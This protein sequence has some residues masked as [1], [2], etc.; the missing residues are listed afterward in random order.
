MVEAY[1]ALGSN[2]GDREANIKAALQLLK[3][4][5]KIIRT[6]SLYETK[7]M[8]IEK[9]D[10]FLNSAAKIETELPPKKLLAI[11]KHIE[12]KLGRK[13]VERNGPR[14]IDLDIL[15]YDNQIVDEGDLQIPHPK[16]EERAFVLIPL[17][18]IAGDFVHPNKGKIVS[19]LLRNLNYDKSAIKLQNPKVMTQ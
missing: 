18:E 19:E 17:N 2:I 16:M 10:W 9:Q 12:K 13:P 5:V 8:Y 14:I 15:F 7:P 11:L 3:Q 6:S 4:R 1:I